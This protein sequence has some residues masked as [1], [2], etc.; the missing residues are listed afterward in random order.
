MHLPGIGNRGTQD[1][2]QS[3]AFN[4]I[5][6]F[7]QTGLV[8]T[9][10]QP[11]GRPI[12]TNRHRFDTLYALRIQPLPYAQAFQKRGVAG[13]DRVD[14]AVPS[15]GVR[16]DLR[17]LWINHRN[18]QPGTQQCQCQAGADQAATNNGSVAAPMLSSRLRCFGRRC[19]S[20]FRLRFHDLI[21]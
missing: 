10:F 5:S 20:F 17:R 15:I 2:Q 11:P 6:Q 12:A 9:E 7:A 19:V 13:A 16:R 3:I 1:L 21:F 14:A 18:V 8:G 4:D